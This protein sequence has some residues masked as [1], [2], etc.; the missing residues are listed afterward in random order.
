MAGHGGGIRIVDV[1]G[2]TLAFVCGQLLRAGVVNADLADV[3]ELALKGVD[4]HGDGTGFG[5]LG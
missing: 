1:D 4:N 3:L 2:D 5:G